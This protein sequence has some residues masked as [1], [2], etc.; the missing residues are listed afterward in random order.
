M[1]E[2]ERTKRISISAVLFLLVIIIAVLAFKQP[3]H[4]FVNN[5]KTT[6]QK[7]I[8]KEYILTLDQFNAIDSSQ[9]ALIDVRRNFEFSKG[10][11][12]NAINISIHQ[13]FNENTTEFLRNLK[14]GNKT[15]ILYGKN[16]DEANS[17]WMLLYQL[18]YENVK[19]LSVKTEFTDNKF[20]VKNSA[21]EKPAVNFAQVMKKATEKPKKIKV[22]K[23]VA[24]KKVAPKKVI[25]KPKKKKR[26]P[27]GGC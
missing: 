12:N 9:Y 7:I 5:T 27:E 26:V 13:A 10:H 14:N 8:A 16:P 17:A 23:K 21:I 6:L 22:I 1:K 2:L 19:I 15:I 24:P 4:I 3:K 11:L 25:P 20:Q 18:G